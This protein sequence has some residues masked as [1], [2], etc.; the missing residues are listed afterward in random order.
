M[1]PRDPLVTALRHAG[2]VFAEEE[3]SILRASA[4]DAAEL[5]R[6]LRARVDGAPL[7]QLVGWVDFHGLRLQVGPH[8]FVP[9]QRT[10]L[11]A[12]IAI[13]AIRT[14]TKSPAPR[15]V[16]A[17]AGVAPIAAAV[18]A[19]RVPAEVF[20]T[21]IDPE[22]LRHAR[23][24]LGAAAGLYGGSVLE[25]LPTDLAGRV[26]V[27]AAVPPYVPLGESGFLP[28]EARDYE[29]PLALFG[30]ED[31]LDHARALIAQALG[32]LAPGGTLLLEMHGSQAAA[33]RGAG[34]R[35]GYRAEHHV[36]A[37]GHT[38]V[39]RLTAPRSDPGKS[40]AASPDGSAG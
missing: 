18:L 33:V 26:E 12:D 7:E 20:A 21:D 10:T 30:G 23:A 9:R 22:S 11:L 14:C 29:H 1:M 16:E 2:C 17:F 19:E 15:F 13:G 37:D 34:E 32:W 6:L 31:G 24:N 25:G 4:L 36:A 27:V 40:W 39:L 38:V 28:R 3:A 35:H 8:V 5:D